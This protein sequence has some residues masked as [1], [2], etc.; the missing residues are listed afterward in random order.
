MSL[1]RKRRT[2]RRNNLRQAARYQKTQK[3]LQDRQSET[4][5]PLAKN[6]ADELG[7][8]EAGTPIT[9]SEFQRCLWRLADIRAGRVKMP[10]RAAQT[11]VASSVLA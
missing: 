1:S 4:M 6:L 3:Y 5:F 8:I 9:M 11:S 2:L 10:K 7:D